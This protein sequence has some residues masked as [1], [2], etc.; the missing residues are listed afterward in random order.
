MAHCSLELGNW[1]DPQLLNAFACFMYSRYFIICYILQFVPIEQHW[2]G[3]RTYKEDTCKTNSR[4][5]VVQIL[6]ETRIMCATRQ[7][8]RVIK[9]GSMRPLNL[10]GTEEGNKAT[11]IQLL[12][13]SITVHSII[14]LLHHCVVSQTI[15]AFCIH[16][17]E[18]SNI[19]LHST[20][21]KWFD[22]ILQWICQKVYFPLYLRQN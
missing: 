16:A 6:N 4:P 18:I 12:Q 13:A 7:Y 2:F 19:A 5:L 21:K 17:L 15:S 9:R 22:Q 10:C 3:T 11:N 14:R 20:C 1:H 8:G